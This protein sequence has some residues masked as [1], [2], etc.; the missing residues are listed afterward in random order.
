MIN[1]ETAPQRTRGGHRN[2]QQQEYITEIRKALAVL[3]TQGSVVELRAFNGRMTWSGYFRDL[4]ALAEAAARIERKAY[5]VYV[6]LNPV[7]PELLARAEN[8]I[9][10]R[11]KNATADHDVLCRHRLLVD[12]DPV[13]PSGISST[14][15]EKSVALKVA[16]EA[17][18]WLTRQ[19]WPEPAIGDSGNGWHLVYGV[20]LPNDAEARDLVQRVLQALDLRFSTDEVSIDTSVHNAARITKLFGTMVRKGDCTEDR[21]HRRSALLE[22]PARLE[23]VPRENLEQLAAM[24]PRPERSSTQG[25]GREFDLERFIEEH[26]AGTVVSEG[27]WNGGRKW[28][29][30][31]CPWN[32]GHTDRAAY[33]VQFANGAIAAGCHHN[34]CQGRGWADLREMLEPE[35]RRRSADVRAWAQKAIE[36]APDEEEFAEEQQ[37]PNQAVWLIR[38]V[39]SRAELWRTPLGQVHLTIPLDGHNEHWPLRSDGARR[40]LY[41]QFYSV[42]EKP[43]GAQAV[44]DA[45]RQ[46]EALAYGEDAVYDTYLRVAGSDGRVYLD[47]GDPAWRAVEI[48]ADGW[49]VISDPP[50]RFRRSP[51]ILPLPE[52]E[53]HGD[54]EVLR[55]LL[56]LP[57][58]DAGWQLVVGWLL[59]TLSP[60]GPYPLLVLSGEHGS[61]K[62]S[63]MRILRHITDPAKPAL[64]SPPREERDLHIASANGWVIALDNIS[65]VPV[66]LSDALCR[67]STGGGQATRALWTNSEEQIFDAQRPCALNGIAGV[68]ERPDLR[69]RALFVELPPIPDHRRLEERVLWGEVGSIVPG[70]LGALCDAMSIALRRQ[71]EVRLPSKPRMADFARLVTAAEPS[72]GWRKG[73]FLAAYTDNRKGAMEFAAESDPVAVAVVALANEHGH[74]RGSTSELYGALC[75]LVGDAT[76]RTKVWP[77]AANSMS[78]RLA[79]LAPVLRGVGLEV[80]RSRVHG[81]GRWELE[82]RGNVPPPPPPSGGSLGS[83][84]NEDGG[85]G[86]GDRK[87]GPPPSRTQ[88]EQRELRFGGDGG[89]PEP[90]VSN[91]VDPNDPATW[92]RCTECERAEPSV[93]P[94]GKCPDCRAV[95]AA[96]R[97]VPRGETWPGL[98]A[99]ADSVRES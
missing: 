55:P 99:D 63:Q 21:P 84:A 87:E 3:V 17:R 19:G 52:P 49:E 56:N 12:F 72:F 7:K 58:G 11:P 30:S 75:D 68:A 90:L 91:P 45:I 13:R 85:D 39:Q 50:V 1:N 48:R 15:A 64:C 61:A 44:E 89:D 41:G 8:R 59:S 82:R 40:W 46:L 23:P 67:L 83:Y 78:A 14:D 97:D 57:E 31:P 27:V 43:P 54:V 98:S 26:L 6:T 35:V 18:E 29:L 96:M 79:L 25:Q 42:H 36:G 86:G 60:T 77:K 62:S 24:A 76:F 33:I 9:L 65:R 93:L 38:I 47:L 10:E 4:H 2:S 32:D 5:G 34:S 88:T 51:R 92:H 53:R 69:D 94:G 81:V 80:R 37:K 66:W 16:Q 74:W 70:V 71:G 20:D 28:V 73:T 22:V 95:D